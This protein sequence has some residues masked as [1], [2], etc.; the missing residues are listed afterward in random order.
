MGKFRK[1]YSAAEFKNASLNGGSFFFTDDTMRFFDSKLYGEWFPTN[2]E[3]T[4]GIVVISNRDRF[5][6]T[7]REYAI[8]FGEQFIGDDGQVRM[9]VGYANDARYATKAQAVRAGRALA[10]EMLNG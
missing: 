1:I 8:V 2:K 5:A 10:D 9:E 4:S 7:P 6:G 3:Q